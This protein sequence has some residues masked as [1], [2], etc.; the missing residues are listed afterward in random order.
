MCQLSEAA[1][2]Q[3]SVRHGLGVAAKIFGRCDQSSPSLTLSR[4]VIAGHLGG[5]ESVSREGLP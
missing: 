3:V 5:S 4:E 1:G 2:P